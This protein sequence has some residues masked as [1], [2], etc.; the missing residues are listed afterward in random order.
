MTCS[1]RLPLRTALGQTETRLAVQPRSAFQSIADPW[2]PVRWECSR[3]LPLRASIKPSNSM[4]GLRPTTPQD[5]PE[6]S[7]FGQRRERE[8]G[9]RRQRAAG[10]DQENPLM[11]TYIIANDGITLSHGTPA[12]TTEGEIAV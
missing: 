11:R 6:W 12:A 4:L 9:N 3:F 1:S 2:A 7:G 5:Y 10:T 8:W